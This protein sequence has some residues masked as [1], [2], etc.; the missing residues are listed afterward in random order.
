MPHFS[1]TLLTCLAVFVSSVA[2]AQNVAK[3]PV[4]GTY[5]EIKTWHER[6]LTTAPSLSQ[7]QAGMRA[8]VR[9]GPLG[10]RGLQR[11]FNNFEGRLALDPRIPGVER[12]ARLLASS[13]KSQRKGYVREVL[14]AANIH[15][16]RRFELIE[17]GRKLDRPWGKTDADILFRH[18]KTARVVRLEVK[19]YSLRS[20]VT[21]EAK[22]KHQISKMTKEARLTGEQQVW[23]NR[24]SVTPE[25]HRYATR[26][27]V[28]VLSNVGTGR[29]LPI[30]TTRFADAL[31]RIERSV[32]PTPASTSRWS[33]QGGFPVVRLATVNSNNL[34]RR[35]AAA[36]ALRHGIVRASSGRS[37]W[38]SV[39]NR[40]SNSQAPRIASGLALATATIF[41]AD[42]ATDWMEY[43]R[44]MISSVRMWQIATAKSAIAASAAGGGYAG[45]TVCGLATANPWASA[46]CGL[47]GAAAGGALANWSF[48]GLLKSDTAK[49]ISRYRRD[50]LKLRYGI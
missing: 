36:P 44:G 19:D 46:G 5:Q 18:K 31:T 21:N 37:A 23:I 49:E 2:L 25:I 15:A 42:L 17:M 26:R 28:M 4:G 8:V 22:L 13:S 34:V 45:A 7:R 27:G 38:G 3:P 39:S 16:D 40:L 43:R 24:R 14:Y 29:Q 20:Q 35:A 11:I 10:Q 9:S 50:A 32:A 6:L 47:A 48:G 41:A 30:G 1:K 12:N 33:I